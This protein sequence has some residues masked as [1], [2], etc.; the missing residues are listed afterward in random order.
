VVVLALLVHALTLGVIDSM[1]PM[2]EKESPDPVGPIRLVVIPPQTA[3]EAEPEEEPEPEPE[4]QL[5]EIAPPE[6]EERPDE[7]DYL[8]EHDVTVEE[9]TKSEKFKVNPDVLAKQYSKEEKAEMEDMMDLNVDKPSTGATEGNDRF[10][11]DRDG[12]LAALP[13]PWRL[14]NKD[15]TAD[16]VPSSHR[17]ASLSGAPQ[18]DLLREKRSD[19]VNLNAKEYLYAGYLQRI[20]RLVNFYWQQNLDNL[21]SS[22]RLSRPQYTTAVNAILNRDGALEYIEVVAE[23]GAGE[24][25]NAVVRAFQ[26]AGPYPNPPEGL[27]KKDGR[28]YLPDMSFT[29][30]LGTARA[31]Y[32]GIDPRAGVQYPGILKSPR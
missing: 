5:V 23:S 21:P 30:Q 25:D 26:V 18:N 28:V 27:V 14:T 7:A 20:R 3:E 6:V 22:V 19:E 29:V 9:E 32:Q 17:T 13:S 2:W 4:G 12:A 11:P 8:A 24:L 15:G 10:D 1:L 16:P 31:Q